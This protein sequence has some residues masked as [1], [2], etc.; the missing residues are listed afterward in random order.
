MLELCVDLSTLGEPLCGWLGAG[1]AL[2]RDQ[3]LW[4]IRLWAQ[5]DQP[6]GQRD[7]VCRLGQASTGDS[8]G[9]VARPVLLLLLLSLLQ[10]PA[11]SQLRGQPTPFAQLG[12][13]TAWVSR[14]AFPSGG[15][16]AFF[17]AVNTAPAPPRAP[18]VAGGQ[19]SGGLGW[20]GP[21]ASF[22]TALVFMETERQAHGEFA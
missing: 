8:A 10:V 2:L 12:G 14:P 9:D 6:A 7:G 1:P 5:R 15:V 16:K 13:R 17:R 4:G 21:S 11:A 18:G 20:N 22:Y 3:G 19:L